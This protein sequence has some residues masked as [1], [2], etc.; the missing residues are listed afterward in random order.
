M[1]CGRER[2]SIDSGEHTAFPWLSLFFFSPPFSRPD[3]YQEVIEEI[4]FVVLDLI[5]N[6]SKPRL[7][8]DFGSRAF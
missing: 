4:P 6:D 1:K 3:L 7:D 5:S 8:P 2:K